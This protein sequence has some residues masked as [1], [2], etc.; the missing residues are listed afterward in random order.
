MRRCSASIRRRE[1][2]ASD[3]SSRSRVDQR[4]SWPFAPDADLI[5]PLVDGQRRAAPLEDPPVRLE[6]GGFA[7]EDDAVE[8]EDDGGEAV[9]RRTLSFPRSSD[10]SGRSPRRHQEQNVTADHHFPPGATSPIATRSTRPRPRSSTTM[11]RRYWRGRDPI[12]DAFMS[13]PT[14]SSRR[15]RGR[16]KI[17]HAR[18]AP[19]S[20]E[21]LPVQQW[22]RPDMVLTIKTSDDPAA[23]AASVTRLRQL[24]PSLPWFE[25]RTIEHLDS[26]C[27]SSASSASRLGAFRIL[28]PFWR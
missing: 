24:D 1:S 26:R 6:L 17:Q 12:G 16:R 7:V 18:E 25:V 21:F 22:Y 28:A 20:F 5:A 14:L 2:G 11:A 4:S 9:H 19:R 8:V 10:A 23:A 3:D 13:A 15:R 27:L